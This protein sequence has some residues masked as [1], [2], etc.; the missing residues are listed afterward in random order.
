MVYGLVELIA[1]A[2]ALFSLFLHFEPGELTIE[3]IANRT[4][5]ILAVVYVM[6]R[7]LDNIAERLRKDSSL[8]PLLVS[9]FSE[10]TECPA[11]PAR[12]GPL[13]HCIAPSHA[14]GSVTH[15]IGCRMRS[16]CFAAFALHPVVGDLALILLG[17]DA[18]MS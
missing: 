18:T 16:R 13:G 2:A 6:V 11:L 15:K 14:P 12:T 1:A 10:V 17:V 9:P 7:A 8:R 5:A 3:F 4:V